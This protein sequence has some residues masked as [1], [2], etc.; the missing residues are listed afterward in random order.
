MSKEDK[1][2]FKKNY[3]KLCKEL[4]KQNEEQSEYDLGIDYEE[5]DSLTIEEEQEL[6]D[7]FEEAVDE[8][9]DLLTPID[10]DDEEK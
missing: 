1:K 4:K 3:L 10:E 8:L 5:E 6:E 7:F 9:V 2:K